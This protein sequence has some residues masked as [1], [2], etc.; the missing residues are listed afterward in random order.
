MKENKRRRKINYED[1]KVGEKNERKAREL[2]RRKYTSGKEQ[3]GQMVV[4]ESKQEKMN[5]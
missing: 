4:G 1:E 2:E 3:Q 5:K